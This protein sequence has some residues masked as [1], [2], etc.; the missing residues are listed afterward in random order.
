M[1]L[2]FDGSVIAFRFLE[3]DRKDAG[4]SGLVGK[5]PDATYCTN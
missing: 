5:Q 2:D 3:R 1:I 4:E